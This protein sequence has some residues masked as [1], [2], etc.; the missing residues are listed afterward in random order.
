M[1]VLAARARPRRRGSSLVVTD[2]LATRSPSGRGPGRAA[3]GP[4]RRGGSC[5]AGARAELAGGAGCE[6]RPSPAAS[7]AV[8]VAVAELEAGVLERRRD[9]R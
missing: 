6:L 3:R 7:T 2:R 5:C 8:D 9:G 4:R 1:Q